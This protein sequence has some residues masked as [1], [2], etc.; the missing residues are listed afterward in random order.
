MGK[1]KVININHYFRPQI[2]GYNKYEFQDTPLMSTYLIAYIVSNFD[3]IT[4]IGNMT[5]SKPLRIYAR[6]GYRNS[7][8]FALEFGEKNMVAFERYIEL[9]YDLPKMDKV[10]I[11][12]FSAGAMENWGLVLYR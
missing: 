12:D 11:P 1:K 10:A 2:L 8:E 5:F 3:Y 4:N 9:P 7:S 6:P